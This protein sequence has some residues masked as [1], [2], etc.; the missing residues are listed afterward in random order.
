MSIADRAVQ[1]KTAEIEALVDGVEQLSGTAAGEQFEQ[2]AGMMLA[3]HRDGLKRML[4]AISQ[5]KEAG[6]ALVLRLTEDELVGNLLMLHDLH[7]VNVNDRVRLAVEKVRPHV[8]ERG[9]DV[10]IVEMAQGSAR[11]RLSGPCD[12]CQAM[13]DSLKLLVQ[14]AVAEAA[15]DLASIDIELTKRPEVAS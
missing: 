13:V 1:K 2:V 4:R 14:Q 5:S 6:D 11:L 9:G 7:P 10:E 15:P 8:Q 12:G 3:I